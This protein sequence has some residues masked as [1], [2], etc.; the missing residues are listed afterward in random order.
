MGKNI[1]NL[2]GRIDKMQH[3]K[4]IEFAAKIREL[5]YADAEDHELAEMCSD[6]VA[7]LE[8]AEQWIK[9]QKESVIELQRKTG[10]Y[11]KLR[12]MNPREFA[13]LYR[14]NIEGAGMF[15]DL[16]AKWPE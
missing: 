10:L 4:L 8:F 11:E 2:I 5:I 16:L 1:E 13:E 7:C 14:K 12:R 15:D 3:E 6:P 9:K